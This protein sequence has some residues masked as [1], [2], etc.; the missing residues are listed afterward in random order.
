[1]YFQGTTAEQFIFREKLEGD[2]DNYEDS[3]LMKFQRKMANLL[4]TVP[5]NVDVFSIHDIPGEEEMVD[6]YYLGHGSSYY[7]SSRLDGIAWMNKDDVTFAF[8]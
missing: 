8:F 7:H 2:I 3:M 5:D 4:G 1:M 6:I